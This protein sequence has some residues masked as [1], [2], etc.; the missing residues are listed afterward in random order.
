MADQETL[1]ST[2]P[3]IR[4][5]SFFNLPAVVARHLREV[6]QELGGRLAFELGGV[7]DVEEWAAGRMR[8]INKCT[9]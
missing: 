2:N 5:Y 8:W 7:G 1:V 6:K 3:H 9:C 4:L